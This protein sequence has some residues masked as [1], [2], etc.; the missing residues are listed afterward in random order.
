[1]TS[2]TKYNMPAT[3]TGVERQPNVMTN[4]WPPW[5]FDMLRNRTRLQTKGLPGTNANANTPPMVWVRSIVAVVAVVFLSHLQC[6]IL[7]GNF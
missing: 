6:R 2:S 7:S 4:F 3:E 5:P 1:M